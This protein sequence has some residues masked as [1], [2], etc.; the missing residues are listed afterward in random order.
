MKQPIPI[1]LM[2]RGLGQGGTERQLAETAKSLDRKLF[3]PYVGCFSAGGM[4]SVELSAAGVPVLRFSSQSY[5]S[6]AILVDTRRML[7][8]LSSREIALVHAFDVPVHPFTV[9]TTRLARGPV[10]VASQ[11][12]HRELASPAY[13]TL[14]RLTDLMVDG[15]VVNC[16]FLAR[17]LA[18][19]RVPRSLI[20]I[21]Y[22]GIDLAAFHPA[23]GFPAEKPA[24]VRLTIGVVCALRPEKNL[25]LLVRAFARVRGSQG[26]IRLLIVGSGAELDGLRTLARELGVAA[27]CVFEPSTPNVVPWLQT[28]DIFVLPS[29]SEAFSNSLMEAMA[30]GCAVV[31]SDTGGNPELVEDGK[32][33][34]LFQSG[35]LN[36][37]AERLRMLTTNPGLRACMAAAGARKIRENFST[38]AAARRMGEIYLELLRRR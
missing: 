28:I 33:G 32:T 5:L 9:A 25:P 12:A 24:Q 21:C 13:R 6:P 8:F 26:G 22:N 20:H 29:I 7:E 3:T 17:H 2:V 34:L 31:A 10:V 37:L 11:R 1:L 35:D 23:T 27:D 15:I 30:C 14:M 4:R 38:A 16:Q 19:E 18:E 36:G